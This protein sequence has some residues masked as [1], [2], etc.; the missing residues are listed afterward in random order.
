MQQHFGILKMGAN[1]IVEYY[2][3]K[4]IWSDVLLVMIVVVAIGVLIA[5][6]PVKY[7]NSK[8]IKNR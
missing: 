2:P 6:I 7:M 8:L 4:V 3:V 5:W 1:F